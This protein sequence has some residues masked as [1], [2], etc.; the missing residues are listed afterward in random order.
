MLT[1]IHEYAWESLT[2]AN[3]SIILQWSTNYVTRARPIIR[4]AFETIQLSHSRSSKHGLH[5][6]TIIS[7]PRPPSRP[8]LVYLHQ[9][10]TDSYTLTPRGILHKPNRDSMQNGTSER[11]WYFYFA[12][13]PRRNCFFADSLPILGPDIICMV[14]FFVIAQRR[15]SLIPFRNKL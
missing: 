11:E 5:N 7:G 4:I 13:E 12:N 1:S 8:F 15:N 10:L 14:L 6:I 3:I 2:P 9:L